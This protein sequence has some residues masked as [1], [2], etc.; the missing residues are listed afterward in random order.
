MKSVDLKEIFRFILV[1]VFAT[2]LHYGI[3]LLLMSVWPVNLAYTSG[4]V[5]S[6][7]FNFILSA[8]FTF[9]ARA[10]L[11]KGIGFGLSHLINYGLHILLLNFFLWLG[12][13][14]TYAPVPVYMIAIPVNF[15]L[16]RFVFKSKKF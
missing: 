9:R 13:S 4:Y 3:Y 14:K 7:I 5:I 16:V 10:G 8:R 2:L 15:I 11:K 1:G 12:I 6:F